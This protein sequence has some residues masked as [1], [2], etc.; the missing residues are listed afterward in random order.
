M[1]EFEKRVRRLLDWRG[2]QSH[3]T[4]WTSRL[5]KVF[6]CWT[7]TPVRQSVPECLIPAE[8]QSI[9]IIVIGVSGKGHDKTVSQVEECGREWNVTC[10]QV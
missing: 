3:A 7:D 4:F 2:G 5:Y 8:G 9:R 6:V 1:D 10:V